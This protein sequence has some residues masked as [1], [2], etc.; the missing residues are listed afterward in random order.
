MRSTTAEGPNPEENSL[1]PANIIDHVD[2]ARRLIAALPALGNPQ[3][4]INEYG[5]PEV[6]HI[7]GWDVG[8]LSALT[9]AGVDS[10]DRA[11]W[12]STQC[13]NPTLDSLLANN[14]VYTEPDYWVRTPM[15]P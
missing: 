14:G 11:C 8:Y 12:P 10:A 3:I 7:P 5:V 2:E 9:T 13:A 1:F 4:F 15:R 6:Q